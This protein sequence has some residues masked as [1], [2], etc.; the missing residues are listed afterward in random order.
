MVS[1]EQQEFPFNLCSLGLV[2]RGGVC[3]QQ[4]GLGWMWMRKSEKL[5][6]HRT[7]PQAPW[8]CGCVFVGLYVVQIQVFCGSSK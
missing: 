8:L 3:G 1:S 6:V 7:G 5:Q 2:R 4:H